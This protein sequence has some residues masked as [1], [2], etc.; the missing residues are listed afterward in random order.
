[1]LTFY[2]SRW[3]HKT[4]CTQH[5]FWKLNRSVLHHRFC[6]C[7][8]T[9]SKPFCPP[10]LDEP[11][12]GFL[13][14]ATIFLNNHSQPAAGPS[15]S[16]FTLNTILYYTINTILYY[17][18]LYYTILHYTTLYYT[19][20]YNTILYYTIRYYTILYYTKLYHYNT[21]LY[22]TI[23]YYVYYTIYTILYY[24]TILY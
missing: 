13:G 24:T 1:M 10:S 3:R 17:T 19:I 8:L 9:C 23:L 6:H 18:I 21:I 14:H 16:Y 22:Y 11:T 20:L 12:M 4:S 15:G 2:S 5:F 7:L